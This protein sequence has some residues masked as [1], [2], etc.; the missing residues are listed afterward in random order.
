MS[1]Q[2]RQRSRLG[3]WAVASLLLTA[4]LGGCSGGDDESLPTDLGARP[5]PSVT[6]S[7]GAAGTAN[8]VL[9]TADDMS[10]DDVAHMPHLQA[11]I[12]DKG[13][14]LE[15]GIAPTPLCVPARASLLTGQYAHNHGALSIE[16]RHGGFTAFNDTDTLP[17]W[18]QDAGYETLFVGKYLNGYG[19][20]DPTYVPEGW[21]DFRASIDFSTYSFTDTKFNANGRV[22]KPEGYNT[23]VI[24]EMTGDMLDS[25][26]DDRPFYMW[27]N[28]VAPHTGGGQETDDPSAVFPDDPEAQLSTTRPAD[29]H[30]DSFADAELPDVPEMWR[31][32]DSSRWSNEAKSEN[33]RSAMR[34]VNQQRLESLQAVDE[35]IKATVEKLRAL[36]EL[37]E[38]YVIVTSDNGFM[39]GHNNRM[40]KLLPFDNSLRVPMLLRGPG[41]PR[42]VTSDLPV[43]N[44]D[45]A[46]TIAS[47]AGAAPGRTMDGV[48][49]LPWLQDELDGQRVIPIEAW[50]VDSGRSKAPVYTGVRYGDYTYVVPRRGDAELYDRAADPGE[51]RNVADDPAYAE[52]LAQLAAWEEQYRDC[53]GTTCPQEFE[54][55]ELAPA[56]G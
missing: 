12:A 41:L 19:V 27:A 52:V 24:A 42:G 11:L 36:G 10:V 21:S 2:E 31:A 18:L 22:V 55:T 32:P 23:D 53:T 45:L 8:V 34:E 6:S 15:Q 46:A 7:T 39:V 35:A 51:L 49:V 25:L 16:G 50:P 28:Y 3:I 47:L 9:I 4:S 48:D 43:T 30:R 54:K 44:P 33:F 38:T 13:V 17:V 1:Q 14:T 29:R 5:S 56:G 26:P 37:D 40:G 20:D